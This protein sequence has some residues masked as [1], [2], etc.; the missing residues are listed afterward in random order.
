MILRF[1]TNVPEVVA[2]KF[3]TGLEAPPQREGYAAQVKFT[4]SD[5]RVMYVAPYAAELIAREGIQPGETFSIGKYEKREGQRKLIR[6]KVERLAAPQAARET[7]L[8]QNLRRSA[9]IARGAQTPVD[10]TPHRAVAVPAP[11]ARPSPPV[12]EIPQ[13]APGPPRPAPAVHSPMSPPRTSDNFAKDART[14]AT[15]KAPPTKVPFEEAFAEFLV[16]AGR[17]TRQAEQILGGE[18]GSV[19]FDSRDVAAIATTMFIAARE[20]TFWGGI[21]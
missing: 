7:P 13:A 10:W 3:A 6:W 2:L 19:R 18:G 12:R 14:V 16:L 5:D 4:L 15:P 8:A 21:K 9:E 20:N 1:S 17:A 11:V